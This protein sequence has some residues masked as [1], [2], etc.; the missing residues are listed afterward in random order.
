MAGA[1]CIIVTTYTEDMGT[2]LIPED[3][4]TVGMVLVN[5]LASNTSP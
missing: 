3:M 2:N 5:T 1:W 4:V